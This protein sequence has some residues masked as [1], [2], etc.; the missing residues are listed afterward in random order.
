MFRK[1][2]IV[3]LIIL[4]IM[5]FFTI[6]TSVPEYD[7]KA[8]FFNT[9][10]A[11]VEMQSLIESACYDCHSYQSKYPWYSNVAPISWWLEDHIEDGRK[12]LNFSRWSEYD[13]KKADHK[14]EETV[15]MLEEKEMPLQSYT[16]LHSEANLTAE[17]RENLI[18]WFKAQRDYLN[19]NQ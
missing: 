14:L 18:I 9:H 8:D 2:A 3:A 16:L 11:T 1:I 10:I 19:R 6:D 15:E 5:Q 12:H 13:F 4:I 7:Q 17:Q